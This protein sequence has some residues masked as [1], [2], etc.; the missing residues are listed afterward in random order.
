MSDPVTPEAVAAALAAAD[1]A[2][3][4]DG[5]FGF[6]VA[7]AAFG[8]EII[9]GLK[10]IDLLPFNPGEGPRA[11]LG[12]YRAALEAAGYR[13]RNTLGFLCVEPLKPTA[14]ATS[15][16]I[17]APV[18]KPDETLHDLAAMITATIN[19][20][21]EGA[22]DALNRLAD[23]LGI[24]E[25]AHSLAVEEGLR[26]ALGPVLGREQLGTALSA[27][28]DA[29]DYRR[30]YQDGDCS[31]CDGNGYDRARPD[32]GKLCGDHDSDEAM[33]SM[34]DLLHDELQ[35]RQGRWEA[36]RG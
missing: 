16:P 5:Q 35:E 3:Y 10:G 20:D 30:E 23:R 4:L 12:D 17:G 7:K 28:E 26:K 21:Q 18:T 32:R 6:T 1:F 9:V 19:G 31:D 13:V 25:D 15:E 34:Y 8:D 29:A 11:L 14:A 27:L 2:E 36:S 22:F 33:A 24:G